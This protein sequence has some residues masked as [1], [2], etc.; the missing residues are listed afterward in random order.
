MVR[1]VGGAWAAARGAGAGQDRGC[2]VETAR[3]LSGGRRR[4]AGE[5]P[6]EVRAGRGRGLGVGAR[7]WAPGR[8]GSGPG[9]LG[10][11]LA[12]GRRR[13]RPPLVLP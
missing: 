3:R 1:G 12:E 6:A 8:D 11:P 7:G 5:G 4:R 13:R 10:R 9:R 2:G